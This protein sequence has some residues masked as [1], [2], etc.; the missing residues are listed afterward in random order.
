MPHPAAH[1]IAL[2]AGIALMAGCGTSGQRDPMNTT[3]TQRPSPPRPGQGAADLRPALVVNGDGV[4]WDD[5]WEPMAEYAGGIIV[6]EVVLDHLLDREM[7]R[8]GVVVGASDIDRERNALTRT[9]AEGVGVGDVAAQQLVRE[10]TLARGLGPRRMEALLRRNAMLRRIASESV[11]VTEDLLV[12][13]HEIEHGRRF[14]ARLI[15]A[16][17]HREASE[18]RAQLESGP[19]ESLRSRFAEAAVE[20]STDQSGAAGGLLGPLSPSDTALPSAL[21]SALASTPV[22]GISPVIALDRGFGVV[23]VESVVEPSGVPL[24]SVRPSLERT[25]RDRL[26]RLEMDSIARELLASARVSIFDRSLHWGWETG[27]PR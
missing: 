23:L 22:G 26:E 15:V 10:V 27:R 4:G 13:A 18:I 11:V 2:I 16:E 25:V 20:R 6:S 1:S 8:R 7:R 24:A 9:I 19:R 5:V 21:R 3:G 12:L 17:G 14:V